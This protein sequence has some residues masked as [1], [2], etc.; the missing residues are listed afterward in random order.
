MKKN[1][2]LVI[3]LAFSPVCFSQSYYYDNRYYDRLLLAEAGLFSGG[4]NCLT[5]LGGKP[6]KQKPFY[7]D[8]NW[9]CTRPCAG[10]HAS[11]LYLYTIGLRFEAMIGTV[12]GADSLLRKNIGDAIHRFQRNL[13][14]RS[15]IAE[16]SLTIEF[17]PLS[18]LSDPYEF[19]ARF[20]PYLVAGI[21]L[22]SF[23][24][25]SQWQGKWIS[26]RPLRTEGQGFPDYPGRPRY[27][28]VQL[29]F[30]AGFGLKYEIS[31]LFNARLE[32][33]YRFLQTDYLDDVSSRYINPALFFR[34]QNGA[35]AALAT[36]LADRRP[37]GT[38][39]ADKRGNSKNNDAYF[40]LALKIGVVL[41]RK[42]V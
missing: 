5:D 35:T 13:H 41:N 38:A 11:I 40:S 12:N 29:N 39:S 17:H 25:Q 7:N 24:P 20:S 2:L 3:L 10:V 37:P 26:L 23:D 33:V 42:R 22:F 6:G 31:A 1:L 14:F 30:P 28:P 16:F 8:I 36:S 34:Y 15:R 18:L 21:G 9:S 32:G 27:K 19:S 4:M